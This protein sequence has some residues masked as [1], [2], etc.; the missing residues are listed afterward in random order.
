GADT[1]GG[2]GGHVIK[3]TNLNATG[4]GSFRAAL[5]AEG[6]RIIVFEVG[7]I[8]DWHKDELTVTHGQLTIAGETAPP[9]GITLI[10]GELSF[11]AP[12][13]IVR[14]IRVRVGDGGHLKTPG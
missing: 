7:G 14:H 12:D 10:R 11:S 2:H 1:P 3:V 8:I 4:E 9:P 6:A 5:E 13:I